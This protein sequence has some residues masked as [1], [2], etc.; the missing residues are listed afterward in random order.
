MNS[1]PPKRRV[2][3]DFYAARPFNSLGPYIPILRVTSNLK[4]TPLNTTLIRAVTRLRRNAAS[5]RT[6]R[7][8]CNDAPYY[9]VEVDRRRN[10]PHPRAHP[11]SR[12]GGD[13]LL[14]MWRPLAGSTSGGGPGHTLAGRRALTSPLGCWRPNATRPSV[15]RDDEPGCD[16][17]AR[18]HRTVLRLV[19]RD[20]VAATR[21]A[22]NLQAA[23]PGRW[24]SPATT[25]AVISSTAT[26]VSR[27]YRA[28]RASRAPR[29]P[30]LPSSQAS[31]DN[32]RSNARPRRSR[33]S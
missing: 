14:H 21:I 33:W 27:G 9:G 26:C 7:M 32:P 22:G 24:S 2:P 1:T 23:R 10:A 29:T 19:A 30:T 17:A 6:F 4:M 25:T 12:R 11:A 31:P 15:T 28:S 8:R 5:G 3:R 16:D 20:T 13:Q 18:H